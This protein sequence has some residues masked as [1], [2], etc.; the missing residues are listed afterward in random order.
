VLPV[1]SCNQAVNI[2][3]ELENG[4]KIVGQ[5][6]ISHPPQRSIGASVTLVDKHCDIKLPHKIKRIF[7]LNEYYQETDPIVN[8]EVLTK[9]TDPQSVIIYGMGSLYT[10]IIPNLI[11]KGVGECIA[12]KKTK[13]ILILNGYPDRET[14]GMTAIDFVMAISNALNR[15][16][17]LSHSPAEYITHLCCLQNSPIEVAK[18]KIKQM[19]IHIVEV[20]SKQTTKSDTQRPIY[21]DRDLITKIM[22]LVSEEGV[23]ENESN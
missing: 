4:N 19:G 3:C 18:G 7:Y 17:E 8:P 1:I 15:N 16:G 14:Y 20:R 13:K 2:G 9:L 12:K 23:L 22:T 6:N 11:L 10:S 21:D 5:S